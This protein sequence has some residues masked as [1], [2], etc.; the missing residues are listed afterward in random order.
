MPNH[1]G[2]YVARLTLKH[3]TICVLVG[4]TQAE[5]QAMLPPGL[6]LSPRMPDDPSDVVLAGPAG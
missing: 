2:K 3:T 5:V 6:D 4:D 1:S